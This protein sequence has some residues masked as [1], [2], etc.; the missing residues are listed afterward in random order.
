MTDNY[1][2]TYLDLETAVVRWRRRLY[3]D[4]DTQP[5]KGE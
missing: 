3:A 2:E 5:R 1:V 4:A